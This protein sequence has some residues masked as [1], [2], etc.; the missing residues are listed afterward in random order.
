M[1][2]ISLYLDQDN[3]LR[4]NVSIEG[5][6]PGTPRYRL[7]F[8]DRS[9]SYSFK[10]QQA[11][12]GEVAFVIPTMKNIIKEGNYKASLEVMVEDR[13]FT[14]LTFDASFEES[15]RVTAES[16]T[17][18]VQ[19]KLGVSASIV[20]A[21]SQREDR[22]IETQSNKP[23]ASKPVKEEFVG[24]VGGKKITAEDLRKIIRSGGLG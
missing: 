18:P 24:T 4:F 7:V 23:A 10:G 1:S 17:R 20:A 19:K 11:S 9:L 3:E 6:K 14:P 5:S 15:V 12:V 2:D 8:E 13:Y 21:P 16:V 22:I